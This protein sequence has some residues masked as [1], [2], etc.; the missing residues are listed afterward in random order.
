MA[1]KLENSIQERDRGIDVTNWT[2]DS[3]VTRSFFYFEVCRGFR[4]AETEEHVA[5]DVVEANAVVEER[6]HG[7]CICGL[8]LTASDVIIIYLPRQ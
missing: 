4:I 8:L 7:G 3:H 5:H 2:I 6:V 1:I